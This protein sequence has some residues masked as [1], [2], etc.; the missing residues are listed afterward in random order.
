MKKILL[1]LCLA[2]S[3]ATVRAQ[4]TN[5]VVQ[6]ITPPA[7]TALVH[8]VTVPSSLSITLAPQLLAQIDPQAPVGKVVQRMLI[9]R[10]PD[11]SFV[12]TITYANAPSGN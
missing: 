4:I 11:G 7:P 5:I 12:A 6:D 9:V 10:N 8:R 3:A 1:L 2:A